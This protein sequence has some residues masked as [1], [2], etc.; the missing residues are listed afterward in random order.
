MTS[1]NTIILQPIVTNGVSK[2]SYKE[3][4]LYSSFESNNVNFLVFFH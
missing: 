2:K 1:S 3:T 4:N